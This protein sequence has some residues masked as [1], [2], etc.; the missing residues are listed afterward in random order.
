[1]NFD[2]R[3]YIDYYNAKNEKEWREIRARAE[4][5]VKEARR[6]AREIKRADPAVREVIL[7]GSLAE[8]GPRRLDFDIDLALKGGDDFKAMD[9]IEGSPFKVDLVDFD[10]LPE[11]IRARIEAKGIILRD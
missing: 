6:L 3:P 7:F 11:H 4:E 2:P 5:A 1:M 9:A 8:E 10:R